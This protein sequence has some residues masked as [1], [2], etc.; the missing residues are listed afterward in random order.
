MTGVQTCA[1]PIS[2]QIIKKN[3]FRIDKNLF[4]ENKEG[5]GIT[6][7]NS[8][9]E[10]TEA[11]FVAHEASKL[12]DSGVSPSDIAVLYRANF[13]SRVLETS[14]MT[15]GVP[16]QVLGV[17]FFDR[18]E[19]RDL[20]SYIRAAL[21]PQS[22]HDIKRVINTPTR[23]I[24]KVTITKIFSNQKDSLP[25]KMIEK[26][27][28]FYSILK[29]INKKTETEKTSKLVTFAIKRSGLEK[30]LQNSTEE[31]M[32]RLEN[33]KELVT[34][35]TKYDTLSPQEGLEKLL[36][37]A[38]L[39]TDQDSLEKNEEA[40]KLMTVHAAKGLEFPYVFITGLE[41]DLFP[42]HKF[43]EN[44]SKEDSEEE[45]RLFYVALTRAEKKL[46]LSFASSR[47][48]YGSKQITIP[49]EFLSDIDESLFVQEDAFV[50]SGDSSSKDKVVYLDF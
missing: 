39:A 20:L 28:D 32:E 36:S 12:V 30:S 13:Q 44:L 7:F 24:G 40:V 16:Y 35:A 47:T 48:I 5:E 1:L 43:N 18:K 49:S 38:A 4:T 50:D 46:F 37:D 45:R 21:N 26:V 8:F 27:N 22:L 17:K 31:D 42:H 10:D 11:S 14:F 33:L 3:K 41:Q 19:V 23:G 6:L 34:L 25:P 15:L 2:N 9:D 29:E